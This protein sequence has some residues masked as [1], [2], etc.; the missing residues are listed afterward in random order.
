V[1][2]KEDGLEVN[3]DKNKYM[4]MFRYQ[5]AGGSHSMKI[6]NSSFEIVE[7]FEYL[8]NNHDKSKFYSGRN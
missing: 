1:A 3:S 4:V 8:G 7:D 2:S 5:N 6:D